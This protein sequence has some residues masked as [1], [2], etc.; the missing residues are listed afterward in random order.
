MVAAVLQTALLDLHNVLRWVVLVAGAVAVARAWRGVTGRAG[1]V[2]T[3][4]L[5]TQVLVGIV[6]YAATSPII[7]A[8]LAN[9]HGA[10][11]DSVQRFWA[12]EHPFCMIL[13]L[14]L[15][16]VARVRERRAG[17]DVKKRR[18]ATILL[19]IALVALVAGTPWPF[20]PYGRPLLP[21]M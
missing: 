17:G 4:A 10:M 19:T 2:F 9:M 21:S 13:A 16:H 12:V 3:I 14:A 15:A 1:L 8:A 7:R 11:K 20:L 18:T 5:D 6:M